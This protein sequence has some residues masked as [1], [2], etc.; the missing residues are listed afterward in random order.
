MATRITIN[1]IINHN[2]LALEYGSKENTL[3][4]CATIG[5]CKNWLWPKYSKSS[6]SFI[7][8]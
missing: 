4:I 8:K 6:N 1:C 2:V 3:K 7:S 5:G